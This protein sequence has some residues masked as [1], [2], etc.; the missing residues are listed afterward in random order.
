MLELHSMKFI[1]QRRS[2]QRG[3]VVPKCCSDLSIPQSFQEDE[4]RDP[5]TRKDSVKFLNLKK[6]QVKHSECLYSK[7][8]KNFLLV[9][10]ER[11]NPLLER[12]QNYLN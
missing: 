7:L 6:L 1:H 9:F 8:G 2:K 4:K 3:C 5:E 12:K 11:C 10:V